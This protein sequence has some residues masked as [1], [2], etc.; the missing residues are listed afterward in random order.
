MTALVFLFLVGIVAMSGDAKPRLR[1]CEDAHCQ[2]ANDKHAGIGQDGVALV[3]MMALKGEWCCITYES[4][5]FVVRT[6]RLQKS[7]ERFCSRVD[8]KR[9]L[10]KTAYKVPQSRFMFYSVRDYKA[11]EK[12]LFGCW[13]NK[14]DMIYVEAE[15]NSGYLSVEYKVIAAFLE[16]VRPI[17]FNVDNAVDGLKAGDLQLVRWSMESLSQE[18]FK[19][20]AGKTI[21]KLEPFLS[22]HDEFTRRWAARMILKI[23]TANKKAS[24]LIAKEDAKKETSERLPLAPKSEN[25]V[26]A[27]IEKT[28][29]SVS[30]ENEKIVGPVVAA[31]FQQSKVTD[32]DLRY[33]ATLTSL[34]RLDLRKTLITDKGLMEVGRLVNLEELYLNE[35][36]VTDEGLAA[37]RNL[38]KLKRLYL[39]RTEVSDKGLATL[40]QLKELHTLLVG[41][42]NITGKGLRS[43][44]DLKK[45]RKLGLEFTPITTMGMKE[46]GRLTQ[47]DSVDLS[48]TQIT[49]A[50]LLS[51][52]DLSNLKDL[53]V[54]HTKVSDTGM[55]VIQR[56]RKL[57]YLDLS[58][59]TVSDAGIRDLTKLTELR[60]LYLA[61][62]SVK[63]A[64]LEYLQQLKNLE[65][66]DVARN[67]ISNGA[68]VHLR[69]LEKLKSL[70]IVDTLI[71]QM[72]VVML[73]KALPHTKIVVGDP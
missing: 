38:K 33:V 54:A 31:Y 15:T 62:T 10:P 68:V 49:D 57:D 24:D 32:D 28:G 47:L 14:A 8:E 69:G 39:M 34:R 20:E 60:S 25:E 21:P 1:T 41:Y 40:S 22:N 27:L 61:H 11:E 5:L 13:K 45:L 72:G 50:D 48:H 17:L 23:D 3:R 18:C 29:G 2:D 6:S 26:I 70:V 36:R 55:K 16:D 53:S 37:I 73:K 71:D 56:F 30:G 4:N 7:L 52:R 65:W 67:K 46:L 35:A 63:D 64:G 44:A 12:G 58:S 42:T 9:L 66:L 51:I 59:T 19:S 43:I